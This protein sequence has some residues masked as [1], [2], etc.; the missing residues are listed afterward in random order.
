[1]THTLDRS[2]ARQLRDWRERAGFTQEELAERAGLTPNA[3]S[4]LERGE[5]THPYPNTVRALAEAL[6][7]SEAAQASLMGSIPRRRATQPPPAA[8]GASAGSPA[9]LPAVD[10]RLIGRAREL[11]ALSHLVRGGAR[12]LTM[13]GPGGVGKTRLAIELAAAVAGDFPD[14]VAFVALAPLADAALVIPTIANTLGLREATGLGLRAALEAHLR[15]RRLLLVLDNFEQVRNAAMDVAALSAH[16]PGLVVVITSR[17][18]L[19]VRGEQEYPVAALEVPNLREVPRLSDIESSPAV[20][21]FVER[22]QAVA[23]EFALS[24]TNASAVAAIARRLEGLPLAIELAAARV[25]L[26]SPMT[27]LARLDPVLPLLSHGPRDLPERQRTMHNAIQWSYDLLSSPQQ[28]VFRR[29]AV[30]RGGWTLEGAEWTASGQDLAN[31]NV[32]DLL[33][34]LNEHSLIAVEPGGTTR[35]RMLEPIRQFALGLLDATDEGE[36][37]RD[38][39]AEFYAALAAEGEAG[40]RGREQV[41]WLARFDQEHDNLRAALEWLLRRRQLGKASL[42]VFSLWLFW[43]MRGHFSEGRRWVELTLA[44]DPAPPDRAWVELVAGVLEYGRGNYAPAA[45]ANDASLALFQASGEE[46]GLALATAM[47]GLI[48]LGREQYEQAAALLD[49]GIE[50]C[51]R[52]GDKWAAAVQLSYAAAMGLKRGDSLRAEE[53]TERALVLARELGD[54]VSTYTSLYNLAS[55]AQLHG[56]HVNAARLFVEGL[57]LSVEMGDRGN[58]AY[59]LEGLAEVAAEQGDA[60]CAAECWSAAEALLA[61]VEA[62]MYAHMRDR[63]R[64]AETIAR[65]R[66]QIDAQDWERAWQRGRDLGWQE[67]L[68]RARAPIASRR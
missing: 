19:R 39:H 57:D 7:L 46:H 44:A 63:S 64:Q 12:M 41:E 68:E 23:P 17:A 45:L 53:L 18:P 5:R 16:A 61:T 25:R 59:C 15:G 21:L 34:D 37:V 8:N 3:I 43:W 20:T 29:L 47:A 30:F 35:V 24:H 13:T 4:A 27:L 10:S 54:R 32:L 9:E 65:T 55:L 26:L 62:A 33:S 42:F 60:E 50:R 11:D 51:L 49:Q 38:R 22:A 58:T 1:M 28:A 48:A 66:S 31:E 56:D 67:V 52:V 36:A 6:G 40:M 14:G 2:F